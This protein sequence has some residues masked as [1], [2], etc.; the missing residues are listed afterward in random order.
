MS[1]LTKYRVGDRFTLKADPNEPDCGETRVFV[2]HVT[3]GPGE[4]GDAIVLGPDGMT[5]DAAWCDE[6]RKG[7]IVTA[8][9][10]AS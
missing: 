8:L 4:G 5:V 2:R 10:A 6:W 3:S 7:A 9:P 1:T